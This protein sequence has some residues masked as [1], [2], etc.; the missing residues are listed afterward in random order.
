MNMDAARQVTLFLLRVVAGLLFL[1]AGGMK[2]FDWFGGVPAQ[3]G[4]HPAMMSQTWIGGARLSFTA[5]PRF[6]SGSSRNRSPS[7]CRGR[8]RW[9][10][11]SSTS[12][13]ALGPSRTTASRP[14]CSASSSCCSRR[15]AREAG[16]STASSYGRGK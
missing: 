13:A 6:Y 10:I 7:S 16:V 1:Q 2:L 3:Y 11:F 9:P 14:C 12:P 5:E 8:W 15:T 4:G